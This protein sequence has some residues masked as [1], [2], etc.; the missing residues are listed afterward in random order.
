MWR[1]LSIQKGRN[2]VSTWLDHIKSHYSDKAL[3][4]KE[5]LAKD[6]I[7]INYDSVLEITNSDKQDIVTYRELTE[8]EAEAYRNALHRIRSEESITKTKGK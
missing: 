5:W 6:M 7:H 1:S 2:V 4:K 3:V 8:S